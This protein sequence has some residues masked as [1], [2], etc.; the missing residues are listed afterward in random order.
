[1]VVRLEYVVLIERH[2]K[3]D[4]DS[5]DIQTEFQEKNYPCILNLNPTPK[6]DS[7]LLL[8]RRSFSS[9]ITTVSNP[10]TPSLEFPMSFIST[11]IAGDDPSPPPSAT[12]AVLKP[13]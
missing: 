4:S 6:L 10:T 5:K 13:R 8:S 7:C 3:R 11:S 2:S 1:M 12:T 9:D